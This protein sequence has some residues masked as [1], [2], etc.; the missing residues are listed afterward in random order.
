VNR[1]V[2]SAI[3]FRSQAFSTSQRF[4]SKSKP[5]GLIACRSHPWDFLP[6][7]FPSRRSRTPLE[8]TLLPCSYPPACEDAPPEPLSPPLSPTPT[9]SRVCLDPCDDYALPFHV[10]KHASW[11]PWSLDGKPS[12][13]TSFTYFEALI[14]SQ[15]R[16][17]P[18]RVAPNRPSLLSRAFAPLELSPRAPRNL[19]PSEPQAIRTPASPRRVRQ[20]IY[21][22]ATLQTR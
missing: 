14:P 6:K 15:V 11:S 4:R 7:A 8:A 17:A 20:A 2:P 19:N 3:R 5:R 13:S 16:S 10:P 18:I 1:A 21:R 12:R 9:L 22:A